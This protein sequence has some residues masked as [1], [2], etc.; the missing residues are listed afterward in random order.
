MSEL[1][2]EIHQ[3]KKIMAN[4]DKSFVEKVLNFLSD[5]NIKHKGGDWLYKTIHA[6]TGWDFVYYF[7]KLAMIIRDD[8]T[9]LKVIKILLEKKSFPSKLRFFAYYLLY[10]FHRN[11]K[12]YSKA[13]Q[14]V[15]TYFGEFQNEPLFHVTRATILFSSTDPDE[16]E[17]AI[18][19]SLELIHHEAFQENVGI[20]QTFAN[21]VIL[22]IEH[23]VDLIISNKS[24]YMNQALKLIQK[25]L[26]QKKYAKYYFTLGI[27]FFY[28]GQ[29]TKNITSFRKAKR[30]IQRAIDVEDSTRKDYPLRLLEYHSYLARIEM[31]SDYL[32]IHHSL[33]EFSITLK[34]N[35]LELAQQ[36]ST[37]F[38][39]SVS[40]YIENL[41][42][43]DTEH[44]QR[45]HQL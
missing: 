28:S 31:Y 19:I 6:N 45:H 33:Q 39:I 42:K 2:P 10:S 37:Q 1:L 36:I 7:P 24:K 11:N 18:S 41:V 25:A 26:T 21:A 27:L 44:H 12:D 16:L 13:K 22:G 3:Y 8:K 34:E 40:D 32:R 30:A 38:G 9:I 15:T 17:Q 5:E 23:E 35:V 20:Y 14:L 29:E 43:I 4:L